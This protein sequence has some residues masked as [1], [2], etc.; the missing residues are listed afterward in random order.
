MSIKADDTVLPVEVYDV[1]ILLGFYGSSLV[2]FPDK[3]LYIEGRFDVSQDASA[4][5]VADL[6][7]RN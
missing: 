1:E 6:D 4:F 7:F 2:L 3:I 5:V